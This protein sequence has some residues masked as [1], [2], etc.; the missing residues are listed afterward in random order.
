M[1]AF[2]AGFTGGL[3]D[4]LQKK[5][6]QEEDQNKQRIGFYQKVMGDTSGAYS[7]QDRAEASKQM[8][9]LLNPETRKTWKKIAPVFAHIVGK[10]QQQ[11][12][13]PPMDTQP[14]TQQGT[15]P[16]VQAPPSSPMSEQ[17][18]G[19]QPGSQNGVSSQAP[20]ARKQA[21]MIGANPAQARQEQ[22]ARNQQA[23][24]MKQ[25]QLQDAELFKAGINRTT[26]RAEE[27]DKAEITA[28]QRKKAAEDFEKSDAAQAL[29]P[30]QRATVKTHILTGVAPPAAEKPDKPTEYDKKQAIAEGAYREAH[31]LPPDA[32]LTNSQKILADAA[33][34]DVERKVTVPS[35]LAATKTALQWQQ[36]G[37]PEE[38]QAAATFLKKK[39][40]QQQA[41]Q[42][43]I[44][45]GAK[46]NA[47]E[48]AP[49]IKKYAE[50]YAN[51]VLKISEI[52]A[53]ER[54]KVM[55]YM[56][57][58]GMDSPMALTPAASKVLTEIDPVLNQIQA[59]KAEIEKVKDNNTPA[60]YFGDRLK[61]AMGLDTGTSAL[62]ANLSMASILGASRILKGGSSRTKTIFEEAQKH[63]P[64]PW[65]DSPKL[66]YDKLEQMEKSILDGKKALMEEGRRSGVP[67]SSSKP[68]SSAPA[69]PAGKAGTTGDAAADAYLKKIGIQ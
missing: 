39:E 17:A 34:K 52:P 20:A 21:F 4:A 7:D 63:T 3:T 35:E 28:A 12:Q 47:S 5:H 32:T 46:A 18:P 68:P 13:G 10:G 57:A 56:A 16:P 49:F 24:D 66:I 23:Y 44:D 58:S 38:K 50:D 37:T 31:G 69:K 36:S 55:S 33:A 27:E 14:A 54:D 30:K 19:T 61:Y 45:N 51:G 53:K 11:Q 60:Y 26:K 22:E 29:D 64:N 25:K 41:I 1:G 8:E 65:K 48:A 40:L 62:L 15:N 59:A 6:D 2:L 67:A 42:I 9:K 43:R